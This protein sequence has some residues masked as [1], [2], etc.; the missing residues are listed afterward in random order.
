MLRALSGPSNTPGQMLGKKFKDLL[1]LQ[2]NMAAKR[3]TEGCST[4]TDEP[5]PVSDTGELVMGQGS[6]AA[7][8]PATASHGLRGSLFFFWDR[9][10]E[11]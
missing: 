8:R 9:K 1:A 11:I 3:K 2:A 10:F 4:M 5:Q 7:N 6:T